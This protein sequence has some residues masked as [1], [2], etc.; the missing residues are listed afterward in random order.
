LI[1]AFGAI[2]M[3]VRSSPAADPSWPKALTFALLSTESAPE[4][5]RR[6]TP[7]LDQ[8][9]RDLGLSIKQVAASD[10]RGSIE[11]L[12]FNKAQIPRSLQPAAPGSAA[13]SRST[14]PPIKSFVT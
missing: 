7:I 14:M 1:C 2:P 6:W 5:G 10:Y 9:S 11:A 13:S 4:L 12:K 3:L 8:L